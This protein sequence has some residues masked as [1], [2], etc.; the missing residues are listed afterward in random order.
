MHHHMKHTVYF[1]CPSSKIVDSV[2]KCVEDYWAWINDILPAQAILLPDGHRC[3][4]AGPYSWTI[5]TFMHLRQA[6]V[7]CKMSSEIPPNGIIISHSDFWPPNVYPSRT[8]FFVE[9]KPDRMKRL[10]SAQFTICQ[11]QFDPFLRS[12][13]SRLDRVVAIGYWPQPSLIP[14]TKQGTSPI[15]TAA[16]MG[17]PESFLH[18]KDLLQSGLANRGISFVIPDRRQWN[19]YSAI[20]LVI[21]VRDPSAFL[22]CAEPHRRVE[23]KPPNKLINAWLA[24]TPA[25]LSPEPSYLRLKLSCL[26]FME[27]RNVDEVL[28]AVDELTCSDE[29]YQRMVEN[30]RIRGA[31]YGVDAVVAQWKTLLDKKLIPLYRKWLKRPTVRILHQ[32]V[33]RYAYTE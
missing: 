33:A 1:Y 31:S 4:W 3:T 5:Q 7:D 2:P 22:P 23:R 8:Q 15:R 28:R 32:F 17:N 9:I 25:I 10:S 29:R 19:D 26:D 13:A 18:K 21:A 12:W 14:R 20:D 6:G 30:A 16:F 11:S 24:E 27:A